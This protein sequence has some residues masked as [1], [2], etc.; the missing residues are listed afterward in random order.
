SFL[1]RV[2]VEPVKKSKI[3]EIGFA[4]LDPERA[5]LIA[6]T[7]VDEFIALNL[8]SRLNATQQARNWLDEQIENQRA[9]LEVSEERLN[10]YLADKRIIFLNQQE[11]YETLLTQKLAEMSTELGSATAYR[12]EK[13]SLA[14]EIKESGL[15]NSA[16]LNNRLI[17]LLQGQYAKL[18]SE[19][20]KFLKIYKPDYPKMVSIRQ[21]MK[22]FKENIDK[23]TNKILSSVKA[24]YN[25]AVKREAYLASD[26]ENVK[27]QAIDLQQKMIQYQIMKREVDTNRDMY[28]SM[29]QRLKEIGVSTTMAA[30]NV[31][32]IDKAEVPTSPF[33]PRK[34]LNMMLAFVT[35]ILGGVFLAFFVDYF[36]RS[37][38]SIEDIEKKHCL[39]VLGEIPESVAG[40]G[41]R[42]LISPGETGAFSEAFRS[43]GTH[44][45]FSSPSTPPK[46]ILVSSSLEQEGKTT[47]SVNIAISLL[48][49]YEKGIII[50]ADM[51]KPNIS[52]YLGMDNS[53]GLSS[54]LS[55][56]SNVDS[57]TRKTA[58]AGLDVITSGP[59]PAN[60]SELLSSREMR[61][62]VDNLRSQYDFI[63]IDSPPIL[64]MS[65]SLVLG[66]LAD[67]AV[68]VAH[69][70]KTPSDALLQSK[71]IFQSIRSRVLGVVLNRVTKKMK[72]GYYPSYYHSNVYEETGKK[73]ESA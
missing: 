35:G 32:I 27:T 54:H 14:N 41:R 50:D 47:V 33:K 22:I 60:P 34:T 2:S 24:D 17:Q 44:L 64:G 20:S 63:I 36:D 37:I 29:L 30:S 52:S 38:K 19:Y 70:G 61:S 8:D 28:N 21:E 26:I 18:D 12:I 45:Q 40:I 51:R 48:N 9:K 67:G 73:I 13:E 4:S 5:A 46:T 43:L 7:I 10:S 31:Q 69:A 57:I 66:T 11:D 15:N 23:E 65:D 72:Y 55:G 6:N 16:V 3:V 49:F 71:K 53:T 56:I 68:L 62:L 42:M 59:K 1:S 39:P 58:Y 25:A